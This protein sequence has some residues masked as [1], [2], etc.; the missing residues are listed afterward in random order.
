[1]RLDE[2]GSGI[3][4]LLAA[5]PWEGIKLADQHLAERLAERVPVLYVDPPRSV[6]RAGDRLSEMVRTRSALAQLGP[7]L[8]RLCPIVQP[9]TTRSGVARLTSRL[10]RWQLQRALRTLGCPVRVLLHAWPTYDVGDGVGE[11]TMVFWAQDDF[12]G[13]AELFGVDAGRIA[14]GEARL[15]AQADLVIAANPGVAERWKA[16]GADVRLI[17]FGCDAERFRDV[18]ALAP[19]A[20]VDLPAPIAGFIGH[21]NARTDVAILEAIADAGISLLMIGPREAGFERARLDALFARRNVRWLG[22]RPF[23]ALPSYLRAIDVGIVPYGDSAFNRGSFPLKTLEYL[24]AGRAVVAT[25]L[26]ATRW[27]GSDEIAIVDEP[28]AFA[29]AVLAAAAAGNPADRK[30]KRQAFAAAHSW[31]ARARSFV[32]AFEE[33]ERGRP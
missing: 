26:L 5:N 25:G 8:A 33:I 13:G 28:R 21:I 15:A 4:V 16:S 1:M 23:E 20:D 17:P 27:L 11:R 32:E 14:R 19:A 31:S 12:A 18:D 7:R 29:A 2:G 3:V 9:F 30:R 10:A 22:P 6:L 24:A